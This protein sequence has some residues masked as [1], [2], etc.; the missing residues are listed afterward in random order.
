MRCTNTVKW[1]Y[2]L[3]QDY[4]WN[5]GRT[6]DKDRVFADQD[7][8]VRLV[9]KIN[10]DLTVLKDYAWDG[11]TP[12]FCLF[13]VLLGV[14][15]GAV[16]RISGKPKTYY[17]SLVHDA[18]YQFLDVGLPFSRKDADEFFLALMTETDFALR[19]IYYLVVRW[20]G[21][22]FRWY[23]IT[24]GKKRRNRPRCLNNADEA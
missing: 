6:I 18:L 2:R 21:G 5:C 14:P 17:A 8:R 20:F 16:H 7:G 9:L 13:D 22:W 12:K 4:T 24:Y 3:E 11:C 23:A 10:G 15:D 19:Y 1:L